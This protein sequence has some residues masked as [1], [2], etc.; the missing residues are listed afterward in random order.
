MATLNL[1]EVDMG[2][3]RLEHGR[4]EEAKRVF[5]DTV[6]HTCPNFGVFPSLNGIPEDNGSPAEDRIRNKLYSALDGWP[7][8]RLM[9]ACNGL[10]KSFM[11]DGDFE[12]ALAWFE[13]VDTIYR[14]QYFSPEQPKPLF[15]WFDHNLDS[16]D[17][18]LQRVTALVLSSRI[19]L[20]LGN[21]ATAGQRYHQ[22]LDTTKNLRSALYTPEYRA[23]VNNNRLREHMLIR[24]PD[25]AFCH[26]LMVSNPRLQVLGSWKKLGER[27]FAGKGPGARLQFSSFIWNSHLYVFGGTKDNLYGPWHKDFWCIDLRQFEEGAGERG[28]K[29]GEPSAEG[30]EPSTVKKKLTGA[31]RRAAAAAAA[32]AAAGKTTDTST[33]ASWRELPSYPRSLAFNGG[34]A[35]SFGFVVHPGRKRAYLITGKRDVDF[36][37]L[38]TEK[39]GVIN[40]S[41]IPTSNDRKA[42]VK[43]DWIFP[44]SNILNAGRAIHGDKIYIFGGTHGTTLLGCNLLVELD[45]KTEVWK[46]LSGYVVPLEDVADHS[47]PDPR[48]SPCCW[49]APEIEYPESLRGTVSA[50]KGQA[51]KGSPRLYIMYGQINRDGAILKGEKHGANKSFTYNDFWSWDLQRGGWRR[52]T[53]VGNPPAQ[54]TEMGYT[55]N[56]RL[57]KV[58]LFGGYTNAVPSRVEPPG[59]AA[60]EFDFTY[61]G[62][63]FMFDY[64]GVGPSGAPSGAFPDLLVNCREPATGHQLAL[65]STKAEQPLNTPAVSANEPSLPEA[66]PSLSTQ[67]Y[68]RWRHVL[69]RGFPTYRCQPALHSDPDTGKVYLYGGFTTSDFIPTRKAFAT[70][71]FGDLWQ[72]RIDIEGGDFSQVDLEDE[73]RTAR[74]GPWLRCFTCGNAGRWK[75]CSGQCK[76]LAGFCGVECQKEGWKEHKRIHKCRKV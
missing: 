9:T 51:T 8:I 69:T 13:E 46:R 64:D 38:T 26:T 30:S 68:P 40:A 70:R 59:S 18:I 29:G 63:T 71:S 21:T 52:E 44:G 23:L 60:K 74:A 7:A 14:N 47:L 20:Y 1:H 37:D 66:P 10:G 31:Q 53:I 36:F 4:V 75:K 35:T 65:P 11:M 49:I 56:E 58:I 57:H 33:G 19:F 50:S 45:L 28:A 55:Y 12:T 16:P 22:A 3:K 32:A 41:Y 42:G 43:G 54:R 2:E 39:W 5:Y 17:F 27:D 34:R 72:L 6:K 25:P 24:N 15:S 73:A 62:D 48:D 61:Y 76:G 67:E